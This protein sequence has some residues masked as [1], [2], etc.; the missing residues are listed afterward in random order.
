MSPSIRL[1]LINLKS[2]HF[3]PELK[4][5]SSFPKGFTKQLVYPFTKNPFKNDLLEEEKSKR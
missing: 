2:L 3:H 5:W 1:E 4:E